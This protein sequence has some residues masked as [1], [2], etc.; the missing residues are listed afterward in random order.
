MVI[1]SQETQG[2]TLILNS[3]GYQTLVHSGILNL[4]EV[5]IY[6]WYCQNHGHQ[7][8]KYVPVILSPGPSR[9]YSRTYQYHLGVII[10]II[11]ESV[12]E[13]LPTLQC[14][15]PGPHCL[16]CL[17]K[18]QSSRQPVPYFPLAQVRPNYRSLSCLPTGQGTHVVSQ[19]ASH[20]LSS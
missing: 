16:L 11:I 8:A 7:G 10:I 19:V 12:P 14:F 5:S 20:S 4:S 3:L 13:K 6:S 17:Q 9:G 1:P 18:G 15:Y 2:Y